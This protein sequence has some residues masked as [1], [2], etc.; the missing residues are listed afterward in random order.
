[1]QKQH[2]V[3]FLFSKREKLKLVSCPVLRILLFIHTSVFIYGFIL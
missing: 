2:L 1:M 3:K